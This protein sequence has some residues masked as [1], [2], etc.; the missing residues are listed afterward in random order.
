M[1]KLLAIAAELVDTLVDSLQAVPYGIRWI[2]RMIKQLCQERWPEATHNQVCS[3]VGGFFVLRFVN[4]AV[5]TPTAYMLVDAKLSNNVRR[6][7][8]LI[9][10]IQQ[11]LANGIQFGDKEFYMAPLNK[12]FDMCL[13][14]LNAFLDKLTEVDDLDV[15]SSLDQYIALTKLT[16]QTISTTQNEI[17]FIHS[18]LIAHRDTVITEPGDEVDNIL[19]NTSCGTSTGSQ[20]G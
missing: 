7:L 2:C 4:P 16:E 19:K 15:H 6:N 10:K 11:N 13:P 8:T 1:D 18:L 12:I 17:A 3:V 9:A 14:K 5:A 20:K